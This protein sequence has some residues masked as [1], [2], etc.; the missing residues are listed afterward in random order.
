MTAPTPGPEVP[1]S[2][3]PARPEEAKG[4][5]WPETSTPWGAVL[6]AVIGGLTVW[7]L[8]NVLPHVHVSIS[9]H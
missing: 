8:V 6:Y 5:W 4:R 3:H 9:W 1:A 7:L 2:S